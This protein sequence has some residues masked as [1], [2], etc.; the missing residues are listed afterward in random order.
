MSALRLARVAV[1]CLVFVGACSSDGPPGEAEIPSADRFYREA[2][3]KLEPERTLFLFQSVDHLAALEGFQIV[4]ENY[5]YS[6]YAT[7]AQLK[8]ADIHFDRHRWEEAASFYQEFVEL[9]PGHEQIPYALYRGGMSWFHQMLEPDQDQTATQQAI[10]QFQVL[11]ERYPESRLAGEALARKRE[12]EDRLAQA[13]VMV[14]DFYFRKGEY[15]S[16]LRRYQQAIS[17][18]PNHGSR[19]RTLGRLGACYSRM[20]QL[21]QAEQ[22]LAQALDYAEQDRTLFE[23]LGED[24]VL[25]YDE[26][27]D[28]IRTELVELEAGVPQPLSPR[29]LRRSCVTHRG[30]A[31][32]AQ[33]REV[34]GRFER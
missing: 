8:I 24:G 7:L 15:H 29:P 33:S 5:P 14:G 17:L 13:D 31:C 22:L 23:S 3:E 34:T 2:L 4:V 26:L 12:A 16:A 6:E 32:N 20:G 28:W 10:A 11:L 25:D 30:E 1:L 19:A 21:V 9:H 27:G 18:Y